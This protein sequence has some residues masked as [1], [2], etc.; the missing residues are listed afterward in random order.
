MLLDLRGESP[1]DGCF[2]AARRESSLATKTTRL[3][4]GCFSA[5]R[6]ESSVA[7]LE[8]RAYSC[9]ALPSCASL[10]TKTT[11]L[12][13]GCSD[14]VRSEVHGAPACYPLEVIDQYA[15]IVD[16]VAGI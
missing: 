16:S 10:A 15:R 3:L 13:V 5:A 7:L 12:L 14:R 8:I 4:V 11:R 2:S 6:G 1:G 9:V